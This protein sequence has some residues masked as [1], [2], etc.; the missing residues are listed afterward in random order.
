M[1]TMSMA[2]LAI[3]TSLVMLLTGPNSNQFHPLPIVSTEPSDDAWNQKAVLWLL[4]AQSPNGGWGAGSH[5]YQNVKDPHAV[6][7]DPATTAFAALALLQ[8]G[9]PLKSNP[10]QQQI[11]KALD[12]IL[13]DIDTR[14]D[15][16][17][18]T[19]L[20][21]TQPQIKLG[22]HIDASMALQFL[23]EIREQIND[24]I[25]EKQIDEAA[26]ICI[27][28]IQGS[29]NADGGWAG[30]GWA[31]VLQ[32]AMAN[33]A[34]ERAQDRYEVDKKAM[35]NS[36]QYQAGNISIDGVGIKAEDAA[37]IPLYAAASAQRATST[38]AREFESIVAP[39]KLAGYSSGK[40]KKSEAKRS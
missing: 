35:E 3:A 39:G 33:N 1:N 32:S 31:P 17:R 23:T 10:Y 11:K 13:K 4:E 21:G 15:N 34:L 30:G 28:L 27:Q 8:T 36:R 16:G 38:E 22:I 6:Q 24:P 12:R 40:I 25:K 29:Q 14:P 2:V 18:I 26:E 19:S 7:T 20:T 37:G 5:A 9:G